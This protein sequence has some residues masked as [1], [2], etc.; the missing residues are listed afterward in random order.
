MI[1]RLVDPALRVIGG[2]VP[3]MQT[4]D[5]PELIGAI[6]QLVDGLA[7]IFLG[8]LE[9]S[10]LAVDVSANFEYGGEGVDAIEV[11]AEFLLGFVHCGVSGVKSLIKI[12]SGAEGFHSVFQDGDQGGG[13]GVHDAGGMVVENSFCKYY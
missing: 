1:G 8:G 11:R 7:V 3:G 5:E 13:R 10:E 2:A 6:L 9:V 4:A 12:A